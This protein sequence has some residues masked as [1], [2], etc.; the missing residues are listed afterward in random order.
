MNR[1]L[2]TGGAGFIGSYIV[3]RL[4][5]DGCF[6]RILDNFSS[7]NKHN[8]GFLDAVE[9][10]LFEVVK[11]DIS[12]EHDCIRA[13]QGISGVFHCAALSSVPL[14]FERPEL[15]DQNN[16]QGT[17]HLLKACADQGI[18]RVVQLSSSS[19][20]G[21]HSEPLTHEGINLDPQSPYAVSKMES[22]KHAQWF[23]THHTMSIV[24]LRC[25]NV[26]G[27][28]QMIN[29]SYAA[30]IPSFCQRMIQGQPPIIYG[31]GEQ[32]RDFVFVEDVVEAT[33]HAMQ[34]AELSGS[35]QLNIASG[36]GHSINQL[37]HYLNMALGTS[38]EPIYS[39][40]RPGD[41]RYS[42]ADIQLASS[43]IHFVPMVSFKDG[44]R[45]TLEWHQWLQQV[46]H[47]MSTV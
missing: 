41:I 42:V 34:C 24:S 18:E 38:I 23:S 35:V 27:P 47:E 15:Y 3:R 33:I 14:S 2:V 20:Y 45:R 43:L 13:L 26:F 25:F 19:V 7:G 44:I 21:D 30:V 28:G 5:K 32:T 1:F 37:V 8:L 39:E 6:V 10:S 40:T 9:P 12:S 31:D 22:E 4:L 29:T 11:G 46:S 36:E 16:T 17:Y